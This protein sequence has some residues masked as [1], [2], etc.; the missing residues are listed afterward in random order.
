MQ[1]KY[2]IG[3]YAPGNYHN[4]CS[5]CE[6]SFFGDKQAV[7]CEPCAL[8]DK[9]R[10][11]A[12]SPAEQ[13][14][15]VKRNVEIYNELMK[16]SSTEQLSGADE[17]DPEYLTIDRGGFW[18]SRALSAEKELQ[19]L[20]ASNPS[21]EREAVE[22]AEWIKKEQWNQRSGLDWA[23]YETIYSDVSIKTTEQ[24]YELYQ[25]AKK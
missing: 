7:Q 3:G 17:P 21:K 24:L 12:L 22:F 16:N 14:E 1:N 23:R 19:E 18:Q 25:Q 4:R 15:L 8:A 5:T 9:A 11:D 2:P 10:F 6:R 13:E 20:K